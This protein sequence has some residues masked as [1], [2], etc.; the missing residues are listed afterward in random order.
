MTN[1]SE[2]NSFFQEED[3]TVDMRT[4]NQN[5]LLQQNENLNNQQESPVKRAVYHDSNLVSLKIHL[6]FF[7]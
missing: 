5:Y 2:C 6:S 1:L 7:K 3:R 4:V